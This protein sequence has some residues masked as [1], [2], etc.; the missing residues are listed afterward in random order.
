MTIEEHERVIAEIRT[1]IL[2]LYPVGSKW[3]GPE[4]DGIYTVMAHFEPKG[5]ICRHEGP[6]TLE[7]PVYEKFSYSELLTGCLIVPR[8]NGWFHEHR[9]KRAVELEQ[10]KQLVA[11]L[12]KGMY[13]K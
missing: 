11:S 9:M 7:E 4:K 12:P 1:Q 5:I 10:E 2:A 13:W 3:Y 6:S 8:S